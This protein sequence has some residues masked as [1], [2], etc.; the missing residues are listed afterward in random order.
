MAEAQAVQTGWDPGSLGPASLTFF[1]LFLLS[2]EG[3]EVARGTP[4]LGWG[5]VP[6]QLHPQA[7]E[8]EA[9]PQAP[10]APQ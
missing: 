8:G 9:S 7:A 10:V 3:Q 4:P 2:S 1:G 5:R 6:T